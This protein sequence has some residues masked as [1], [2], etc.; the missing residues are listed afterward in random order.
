MKIKITI[1]FQLKDGVNSGK[2]LPIDTA[3]LSKR[4]E[5]LTVKCSRKVLRHGRG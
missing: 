5:D 1:H 2:H 3:Q 4:V